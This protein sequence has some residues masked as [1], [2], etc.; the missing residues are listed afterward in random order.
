MVMG[1]AIDPQRNECAIVFQIQIISWKT[2][3]LIDVYKCPKCG[4]S[5]R[6]D[7]E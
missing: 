6:I 5:E 2:L 3:K 1:K 4:H 7:Y